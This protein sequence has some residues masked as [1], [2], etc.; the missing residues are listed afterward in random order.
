MIITSLNN[1]QVMYAC[2]LKEKKISRK[3]GPI[4]YLRGSF[5]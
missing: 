1:K 5:D 2:S 3:R 4:S